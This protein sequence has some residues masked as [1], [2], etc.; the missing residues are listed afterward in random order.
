MDSKKKFSIGNIIMVIMLRLLLKMMRKGKPI[1]APPPII[2]I[3]KKLM[4]D[5]PQSDLTLDRKRL[6]Y[7]CG[8]C[9]QKFSLKSDKTISQQI[10]KEWLDEVKGHKCNASQKNTNHKH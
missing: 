4:P 7:R 9:G 3:P 5:I 6:V 10:M 2:I 1:G 8:V